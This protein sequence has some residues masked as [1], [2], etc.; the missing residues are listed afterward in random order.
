MCNKLKLEDIAKLANV[1]KSAVSLALN[2][3]PGISN[4]TR[5]KILEIVRNVGYIPRTMIRAEQVY[6]ST[7]T[8][9]FIACVN[10]GIV[11]DQYEKQ[12]FFSEL[13]HSLGEFSR[14]YGYSLLFSP[15]RYEQ[16]DQD[17]EHLKYDRSSRGIILLGTNMGIDQ[18]NSIS[19]INPN[20]V[21]IDTLFETLPLN[22]VVMNNLMGSYQAAE[23]LI[24]LGHKKIGYVESS[25]RMHNFDA[26]KK[27]FFHY[28]RDHGLQIEKEN[29]FSIVPTTVQSQE[30]FKSVIKSRVS[31]SLPTALFCE[32]DYIAISVIK[33]LR[34]LGIRVPEDISVMGFDNIHEATVITPELSTIHV[35]K[36]A[37]AK[38]AIE[39]LIE[40]D[41]NTEGEKR[42]VLV[43]T[44]LIERDSCSH[45]SYSNLTQ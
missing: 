25:T 27:G 31:S 3:K 24:R 40:M 21:V 38:V 18:I 6:T 17:I 32:C 29:I 22:F 2:N 13:I 34:E 45:L 23:Y 20:V 30:D 44:K 5:E 43:D 7:K 36:G 4:E 16:I 1:S 11:L 9:Q 28:T 14:I 8:I 19:E 41:E 39:M 33:S 42:K 10:S 26:R 15:I 37:M 12:P 35:A